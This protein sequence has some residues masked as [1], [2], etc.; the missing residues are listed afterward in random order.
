MCSKPRGNKASPCTEFQT[1]F[2]LSEHTCSME[3]FR[4]TLYVKHRPTNLNAQN[5]TLRCGFSLQ[6]LLTFPTPE[7]RTRATHGQK[8]GSNTEEIGYRDVLCHPKCDRHARHASRRAWVAH[9][10]SNVP[11]GPDTTRCHSPGSLVILQQCASVVACV[12]REVHGATMWKGCSV[13]FI[14]DTGDH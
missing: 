12:A 11:W 1:F 4:K 7:S 13:C 6:R 10:N 5:N 14:C 3:H 2:L 8:C 9:H